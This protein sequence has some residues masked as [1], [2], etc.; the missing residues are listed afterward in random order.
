MGIVFLKTTSFCLRLTASL[1]QPERIRLMVVIGELT[2]VWSLCDEKV[3]GLSEV[4]VG[5]VCD[6]VPSQLT[7]LK[8]S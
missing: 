7:V 1:G 4:L 5:A 6:A 2:I 8:L 3:Q